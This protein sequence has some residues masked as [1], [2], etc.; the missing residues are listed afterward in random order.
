MG[1]PT[2]SVLM[3]NLTSLSVLMC[4][5]TLSVLMG[6]PTLSVLMDSPSS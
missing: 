3:G 5:P 6:S 1:S 2:L 4:S